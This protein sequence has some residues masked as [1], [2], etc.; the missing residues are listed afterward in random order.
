MDLIEF[1]EDLIVANIVTPCRKGEFIYVICKTKYR[2]QKLRKILKD[3]LSSKRGVFTHTGIVITT[4]DD[5]ECVHKYVDTIITF[6][7]NHGR[8]KHKIRLN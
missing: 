8:R 1:D 6:K 3:Y 4:T 5:R 7:D 2:R